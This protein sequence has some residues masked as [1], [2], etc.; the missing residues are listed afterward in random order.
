MGPEALAMARR[1]EQAGLTSSGS[2]NEPPDH[3]SI[4]L[5]YL[6]FLLNRDPAEASDFAHQTMSAW[7]G[8]FA[9][10]VQAAD[11]GGFFS[12]GT[13]FTSALLQAVEAHKA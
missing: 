12:V 5:E 4:E 8:R 9:Q 13:A 2:G 3:L 6:Y 10:A 1:L 7:V 11:P